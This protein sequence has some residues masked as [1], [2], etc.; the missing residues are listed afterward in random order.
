M[1]ICLRRRLIA[2]AQVETDHANKVEFEN[3]ARAYLRLAEQ[4][5]RN[6]QAD[7]VSETPLNKDRDQA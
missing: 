5:E 3:L 4:A 1:S 2:M 7:I 6:S